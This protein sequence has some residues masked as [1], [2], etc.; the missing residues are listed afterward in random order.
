LAV[1]GTVGVLQR[2]ARRNLLDLEDAVQKLRR[3]DFRVGE[4]VV[5]RILRDDMPGKREAD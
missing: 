5:R 3:T 1:I 4:E 2:A